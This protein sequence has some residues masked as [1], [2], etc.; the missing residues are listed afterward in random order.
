MATAC[1]VPGAVWAQVVC[2]FLFVIILLFQHA[3]IG[4][5]GM[6]CVL[7]VLFGWL[8]GV[9]ILI[10]ACVARWR[11]GALRYVG[12]V[13]LVAAMPP[14]L[15]LVNWPMSWLSAAIRLSWSEGS[16]LQVI[17]EA[18][19]GR[20]REGVFVDRHLGRL[21]IVPWG[22]VGLS[23]VGV[24]LD[25]DEGGDKNVVGKNV[26]GFRVVTARPLWGRWFLVWAK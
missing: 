8:W 5:L 10:A 6:G 13:A 14:G 26:G 15:S 9:V 12:A 17:D 7:L 4:W 3:V 21:A 19:R 25:Q 18:M 11:C 16:Y 1:G 22:A 20:E 24:M 23:I 2:W